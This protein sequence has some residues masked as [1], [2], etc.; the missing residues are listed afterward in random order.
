VL[1]F[2]YGYCVG[3]HLHLSTKNNTLCFAEN[4]QTLFTVS[5]ETQL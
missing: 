5:C 4:I 2:C 3:A 1:P